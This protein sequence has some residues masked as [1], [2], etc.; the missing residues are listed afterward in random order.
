MADDASVGPDA[1]DTAGRR[2]LVLTNP[3]IARRLPGL[4]DTL[5]HALTPASR[6]ES[7]EGP[8][9]MAERALQAAAEGFDRIAVAGGD[10]T[11]GLLLRAMIGAGERSDSVL[12]VIPLGTYN[13]FARSLGIPMDVLGACHL[14][15]HGQARRVD[16]GRVTSR[17]PPAT[18]VFKEIAGVGVDATA[19]AAGVDVAGLIKIPVGAMSAL[20]AILSY[21]PHP[22]RYRCDD[23]RRWRRCT[24]LLIANTPM[25]GAAFPV[26]PEANAFDGR[27]HVLG[28][29]WRGRLDLLRELRSI[30]SGR[31]TELEEDLVVE[32]RR[33]LVSGHS[34]VL[35]HADGEFF[36][37]M[38]AAIEILPA[39]VAVVAPSGE[40]PAVSDYQTG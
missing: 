15:V 4:T 11:V 12:G 24:Q 30:L 40:P 8:A 37:R 18:F 34:N 38:P 26:L 33:V 21:R 9:A 16:L 27:F 2:I 35:L 7:I 19:F 32:C 39:A 13:N 31:H 10:G 1:P 36:C 6:I 17:R 28:R 23:E 20:S 5:S 3:R 29:N 14:L 25:Y 22:V